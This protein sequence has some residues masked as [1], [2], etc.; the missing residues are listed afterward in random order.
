MTRETRLSCL[1]YSAKN[2]FNLIF[3]FFAKL[4]VREELAVL[5]Y[6][7]VD[8]TPNF[9]SV[10]P[11]EFT[12]QIEY[13][14][15]NYA[16]VSLNEMVDFA[17]GSRKAPRKAVAITFDDGSQDL[18]LSVY[19]YFR[20]NKLPATVFI[21]TGYVG[22]QWPFY[23]HPQKTLDWSEIEEMSRNNFEI[24]A[25]TVHHQN[26]RNMSLEEASKEISESKIEIEN[27]IKKSVNFFSYPF[28]AYTPEV[29]NV[30]RSL[31]FK[32][33][34]GGIGTISINPQIF[35]LNRIQVDKSIS[36]TVF[37]ARLTKAF[38]LAT[39]LEMAAHGA[40]RLLFSTRGQR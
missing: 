22:K 31:G 17:K 14:R 24:G 40:W 37:I 6:H 29:V 35:N 27:H 34:V 1:A 15:K 18:Y 10:D 33:G 16:I 21:S 20:K 25:H 2:T 8:L 4:A 7:S 38:D 13:L 12:R 30:V 23:V 26:L 28:G 11:K 36:F 9:H 19:P 3:A 32:G 5:M 39:K